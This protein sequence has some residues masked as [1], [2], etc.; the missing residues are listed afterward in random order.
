MHKLLLLSVC[1]VMVWGD[2]ISWS[3]ATP[4]KEPDFCG[5]SH[6]RYGYCYFT[7]TL[8]LRRCW[9]ETC[10]NYGYLSLTFSILTIL[11]LHFIRF[12]AKILV[13]LHWLLVVQSFRGKGS[14]CC[15]ENVS[16]F[17]ASI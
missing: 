1:N 17:P 12:R 5:K 8:Y 2:Q 11:Y 13:G 3:E 10:W 15:S 16:S 6:Y 9:A 14:P 4:Q 7:T